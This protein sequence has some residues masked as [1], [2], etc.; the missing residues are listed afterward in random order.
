[1]IYI[2]EFWGGLFHNKILKRGTESQE[3]KNFLKDQ[4][5]TNCDMKNK[6]SK[7]GHVMEDYVWQ[8][9]KV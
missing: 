4:D 2:I 9:W 1:M 6:G 5:N 7:Q 3:A 8:I